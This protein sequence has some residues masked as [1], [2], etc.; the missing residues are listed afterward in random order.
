[1]VIF[2]T[3][4]RLP[5]G[6]EETTTDWPGPGVVS[7]AH[8]HEYDLAALDVGPRATGG[9]LLCEGPGA[10]WRASVLAESGRAP[11]EGD[12]VGDGHAE[13]GHDDHH[14][15]RRAGGG[16]ALKIETDGS[17]RN[18]R[19]AAVSLGYMVA[20]EFA[21]E[22]EEGAL[23]DDGT[24]VGGEWPGQDRGFLTV[25]GMFGPGDIHGPALDAADF[26]DPQADALER[27]RASGVD[28][29]AGQP[30][31]SDVTAVATG[32]TWRG[33]DALSDAGLR[34]D[35]WHTSTEAADGS[36]RADRGGDF[37]GPVRL[38]M[39]DHPRSARV[40]LAEDP[41]DSRS[42]RGAGADIASG[43]R[44]SE[45]GMS[46]EDAEADV[47]VFT[48]SEDAPDDALAGYDTGTDDAEVMA[49]LMEEIL[50][51][52]ADGTD[53]ALFG[54]T[55]TTGPDP[56]GAAFAESTPVDLTASTTLN[57]F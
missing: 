49:I 13:D 11:R 42:G 10:S 39:E 50:R 28:V 54:S 5:G 52:Y 19:N 38:A 15:G 41:A 35:V 47:F 6:A 12:A 40:G 48:D 32:R 2:H 4:G 53:T 24:P 37:G 22:I 21:E 36:G 8:I 30:F 45:R 1:M 33:S 17:V 56:D 29:L 20:L 57:D 18:L 25:A 43:H 3:I 44:D 55:E 46:D 27:V 14:P 23:V 31:A 16:S 51:D 26:H 7:A 34:N 9:G